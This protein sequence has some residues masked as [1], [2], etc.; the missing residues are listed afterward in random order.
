MDWDTGGRF[1]REGTRVYPWLTHVDVR[2]KPT[3]YFNAII[4]QLKIK[5]KKISLI[6][7][8]PQ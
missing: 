6:K 4:L 7:I 1:Q 5:L 3:K 2:Q 8:K